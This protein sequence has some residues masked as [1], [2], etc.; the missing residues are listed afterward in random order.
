MQGLIRHQQKEYVI[1]LRSVYS[2]ILYPWRQFSM[3]L[4]IGFS[5]AILLYMQSYKLFRQPK[6]ILVNLMTINEKL[7]IQSK[8][9]ALKIETGHTITVSTVFNI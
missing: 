1:H 9:F 3:D 8:E 7:L 5:A 6:A 2:E 4:N